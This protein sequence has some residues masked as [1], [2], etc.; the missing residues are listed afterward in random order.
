MFRPS[1]TSLSGVRL[2]TCFVAFAAGFRLL[3]LFPLLLG[4]LP[5]EGQTPAGCL[6]HSSYPDAALTASDGGSSSVAYQQ[7]P[8]PWAGDS[9]PSLETAWFV[10]FD[11]APHQAVFLT[12]AWFKPGPA[13]SFVKVLDRTGLSELYVFYRGGGTY[14]ELAQASMRLLQ[15]RGQDAGPCGL[16]VGRSGLV[17]R[18]VVDKGVLW[19]DGQR[20]VRGQLMALW[21][22]ID[23]ENYNYV[24]K[25]EFH[26]DGT[27][28][29]TAAPT[30]Q[31]LPGRRSIAHTHIAFWRI[32]VDLG[33]ADGD[34]AYVLRHLEDVTSGSWSDTRE[35]F[36]GGTEGALAIEATEFTQL[37]VA[38][39]GRTYDLRPLFRGLARHHLSW[40]RYD[41]ATSV[42]AAGETHFPH[43]DRY[44]ADR[45]SVTDADV[46]LWHATSLLHVPRGE[47]GRF[48]NGDWQGV[49]LAMPAGFEFRPRDLFDR[50]PFHPAPVDADAE[51]EISFGASTYD[52]EEGETVTVVVSLNR[53]PDRAM[54]IDLVLSHQ[55]GATSADYSGVPFSVRFDPGVARR[56]FQV[57]ATSDDDDEGSETVELGFA[58]LP[59]RV[60]GG[61]PSTLTIRDR[62]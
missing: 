41:F 47:D 20:V 30:A 35:A 33:G 54:D 6:V 18:E 23:V 51:V 27:I 53:E 4:S 46:V 29:A 55:G 49:A 21:G 45:Q 16:I 10:T 26:D 28:R 25:Y 22:T 58:A 14:G 48:V 40:T 17:V 61:D 52:V 62:E 59:Q 5:A 11:H 15:A 38:G 9:E 50:T 56:E 13:E 57:S 60:T 31:N 36:N 42:A 44:V 37:Q 39:G 19:K 34:S 1:P 8:A 12:G 2:R 32:D 7:F 24:L 3:P 43:L